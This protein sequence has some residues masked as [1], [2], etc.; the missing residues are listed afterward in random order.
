MTE[1]AQRL[2]AQERFGPARELLERIR[3]RGDSEPLRQQ[4][5]LCTYKDPDLPALKRLEDALAILT[6][7][8]PLQRSRDAETLG[9]AGAIHKRRWALTADRG[10]LEDAHWCYSRGFASEGQERQ[11]Y[12][13]INAA[14]VADQLA[15]LPRLGSGA[16]WTAGADAIREQLIALLPPPET[17]WE[18]ATL[19][20]AHLGLGQIGKAREHLAA[21]RELAPAQWELETTA[22]QLAELIRLRGI[23]EDVLDALLGEDAPALARASFG[24]VGLALSGGGFRASLFHIGVLAR[25][26]EVD[27]L[28]QVE[29]L[30][31]VSGGS[32]LGAFYT[33]KLKARLE[34]QADEELTQE[35]FVALVREVAHEFFS[36]VQENLRGRLVAEWATLTKGRT[37]RAAQLIDELLLARVEQRPQAGWRMSD[38]VI[39]PRG[40][41]QRENWR[42]ASKVPVLVIN[43]TT[44]NT[45]HGWQF[46][47]TAM[48][49]SPVDVSEGESS[50]PVLPRMAYGEAPPGH[51]DPE[52]ALAVAASASVPGLFSPV[53]LRE[54]YE[55]M[56]VRLIDGGVHDNQGVASLLE[57]DCAVVLVSDASGQLG[58]FDHPPGDPIRVLW[59]TNAILMG[60]VRG[61]QFID[62]AAR[63]RSGR[64]RREL[65]LHLR[66]GLSVPPRRVAGAPPA[67]PAE[68]DG[69]PR[70]IHADVQSALAAL[71]TDLDAF[72]DDEAYGLMAAGYL[73][74][75]RGL[76]ELSPDFAAP[77]APTAGWPFEAHL[78]RLA[79]AAFALELERG[80]KRLFRHWDAPLPV[81][82]LA[83]APIAKRTGALV[84]QA[85]R[86]LARAQ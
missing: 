21:L 51:R 86:V 17:A 55:G 33:L 61:A 34:S 41:P 12:C 36:G 70:E 83:G 54:L 72:T 69:R 75:R 60:R 67:P 23:E 47:P 8:A 74:A 53:V 24:K 20:E 85:A 13:G 57:R 7:E 44:L 81:R 80:R 18:H 6:A 48:G 77:T 39:R 11:A 28:R 71:R 29:V 31:C 73:M 16:A 46:T 52:L 10:D 58:G 4:H 42:R 15:S 27:L 43:A 62:L 19:A 45:G 50:A 3:A 79:E 37:H 5:A 84:R 38:L 76:A 32:I 26:A 56:Q 65:V 64:L 30:S 14:F 78:P 1:E 63:V 25:L 49:E 68:V 40:A 66:K 35:D 82:L 2:Q 22:T 9:I 59:R